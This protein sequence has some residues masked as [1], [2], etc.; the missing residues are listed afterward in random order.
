MKIDRV[1]LACEIESLLEDLFGAQRRLTLIQQE[2]SNITVKTQMSDLTDVRRA[3][4]EIDQ[5]ACNLKSIEDRLLDSR[6]YLTNLHYHK[7]ARFD[8]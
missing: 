4:D 3:L 6:D 5:I 8:R 2:A 1:E 7:V